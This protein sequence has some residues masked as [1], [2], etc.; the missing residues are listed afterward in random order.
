MCVHTLAGKSRLSQAGLDHLRIHSCC[1][2]NP[3]STVM[4]VMVGTVMV[5]MIMM[6]Q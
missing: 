6:L 1:H 5:V 2:S 3:V 4:M